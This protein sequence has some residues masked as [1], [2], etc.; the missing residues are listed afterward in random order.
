MYRFREEPEFDEYYRHAQQ[1]VCYS[2]WK[3][4]EDD[5]PYANYYQCEDG[6][7]LYDE[8]HS[9]CSERE[10]DEAT[11]WSTFERRLDAEPKHGWLRNLISKWCS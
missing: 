9:K 7:K 5:D 10:R 8:A 1:E 11:D 4:E 6:V 3:F 2:C